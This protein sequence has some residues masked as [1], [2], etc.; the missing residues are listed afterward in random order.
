[1]K[2]K[3]FSALTALALTG[4]VVLTGC[5]TDEAAEGRGVVEAVDATAATVTI[6]GTAYTAGEGVS[7]APDIA[8]GDSVM[9]TANGTTVTSISEI[10]TDMGMPAPMD[11][12]AAGMGAMADSAA[13]GMANMAD[14]AAAGMSNMADSVRN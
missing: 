6:G 8:V 2:V 13:M 14:S 1:M 10:M 5:K 12:A 11:S 3:F 4:G 9:Y 7:I